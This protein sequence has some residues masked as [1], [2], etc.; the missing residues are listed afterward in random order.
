M[1]TNNP[2]RETNKYLVFGQAPKR[3]TKNLESGVP[4]IAAQEGRNYF[5]AGSIDIRSSSREHVEA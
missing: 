4:P 1:S 5:Y 3:W 2:P